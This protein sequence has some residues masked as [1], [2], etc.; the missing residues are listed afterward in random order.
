MKA[1]VCQ[2]EVRESLISN[3]KRCIH[4]ACNNAH[5]ANVQHTAYTIY[6]VFNTSLK[7]GI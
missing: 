1:E 5:K 2:V 4:T 6:Y 3:K 7:D